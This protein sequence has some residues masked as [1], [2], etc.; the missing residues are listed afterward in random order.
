MLALINEQGSVVNYPYYIS[1]YVPGVPMQEQK[2]MPSISNQQLEDY[3]KL[4]PPKTSF[5][6][7]LARKNALNIL[8]KQESDKL[9]NLIVEV[10]LSQSPENISWDKAAKVKSI[11]K[12]NDKYTAVF[13]IV[14]RF[15]SVEAKKQFLKTHLIYLKVNNENNLSS[16]IKNLKQKYTEDEVA[17]WDSQ[18]AQALEFQKTGIAGEL[19]KNIAE[20]RQISIQELVNKIIENSNNYAISVGKILGQ[21]QRNKNIINSINLEDPLTWSMLDNYKEF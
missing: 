9:K 20:N 8:Q 2:L 7:S 11:N 16:K 18:S 3:L 4:N 6:Y 19:I 15:D 5:E 14:D 1:G 17:T 12:V 21:Y 10:D 13:E